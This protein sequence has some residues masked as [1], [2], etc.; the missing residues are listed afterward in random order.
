MANQNQPHSRRLPLIFLICL[1]CVVFVICLFFHP[2]ARRDSMKW[3]RSLAPEEIASADLI[4]FPQAQDKQ[5]RHLSKDEISHMVDLLHTGSGNYRSEHEDL[6]GGSI[7]F[8]ISMTDGTQHSVGNIGNVYLVIDDDYFEANYDW[9][10]KWDNEFGEGDSPIPDGYFGQSPVTKWF[11]YLESPETIPW[12]RQLETQIPQF[13]NVTFRYTP[14]QIVATKT[15]SET[16]TEGHTI[17]ISGTPIYNAYFCDLTGDGFPE[18][19][20]TYLL[21]FGMIDSR[22]VMYDYVNGTSYELSNR[23]NYDF[24]LRW[25]ERDGCLYVDKTDYST[26]TLIGSGRLQFQDGILQIEG[27]PSDPTS[28]FQ[29]T[30]LEVENGSFLVEPAKDTSEFHV[31]SR[32]QVPITSMPASPEPQVG[33]QIE[34]IYDGVIAQTDPPQIHNVKRIRILPDVLS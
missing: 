17:L 34:I 16:G 28:Q 33:D 3:V 8:Y 12:D 10:S 29:A 25:N 15:F 14:E 24:S 2:V 7:F 4:V 31:A 21:G 20:S 9:L 6:A 27:I 19:C 26:N 32:I 23:G 13:P 18:L 5:F 11:D 1:I 30:I 22:V